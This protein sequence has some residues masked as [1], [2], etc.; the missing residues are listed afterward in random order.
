[1]EKFAFNRSKGTGA[2]AGGYGADQN[3]LAVGTSEMDVSDL[4]GPEDLLP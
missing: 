3:R 4:C 2:G 1:M